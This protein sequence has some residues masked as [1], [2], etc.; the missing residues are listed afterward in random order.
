MISLPE[1][2]EYIIEK[3][4]DAGYEAYIVGGCVRD[5]LI[6]RKPEDWDIA[7]NAHPETVQSLFAKTLEIGKKFGTIK[8]MMGDNG[9]EVTTFRSDGSYSDGRRPDNVFFSD[10]IEEDLKRRDF[11]INAMAYNPRRGLIDLHNGLQHL[12]EG[13]IKCVGNANERFQEDALRMLRCIRFASQYQFEIER[14]TYD[15]LVNN[16]TRINGISAE[17]IR[18]EFDKIM[19]SEQPYCGI[20]LLFDTGIGTILINDWENGLSHDILEDLKILNEM[21]D[22]LD[23]RLVHMFFNIYKE[24]PIAV[25]KLNE[26]LSRYKYDKK[27]KNN[28]IALLEARLAI[29]NINTSYE[30][31]KI[32]QKLGKT[33]FEQ[34]IILYSFDKKRR[35]HYL[36]IEKLYD[37]IIV[38]NEPIS[39]EDLKINGEDIS[40]AGFRGKE[41]GKVIDILLDRV[42]YDPEENKEEILVEIIKQIKFK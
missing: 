17:R 2:V 21:P 25:A 32:I 3:L 34:L 33:L 6:G 18:D 1:D 20:S 42:H 8:V 22:I 27:T 28:A 37:S 12:K 35:E 26:F 15:A 40:E 19:I 30:L 31:K 23:V 13:I 14:E 29:F 11:T 16:R 10:N 38:N 9:Y 4:E 7:A 24:N 41:I 5:A 36:H 39:Y